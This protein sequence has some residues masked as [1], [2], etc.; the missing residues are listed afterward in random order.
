MFY[1]YH[2]VAEYHLRRRNAQLLGHVFYRTG[3]EDG[4]FAR[5]D[6]EAL[7]GD[8]R[9]GVARCHGIGGR[10]V[11]RCHIMRCMRRDPFEIMRRGE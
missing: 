5:G 8:G 10:S 7:L 9:V 6:G 2:V 11:E 4:Q 1:P 3:L